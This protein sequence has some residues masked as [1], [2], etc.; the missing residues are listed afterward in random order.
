MNTNLLIQ[1]PTTAKKD[2]LQS[3]LTAHI[4][5]GRFDSARVAAAYATVSGVR[6]LLAAFEAH[7]LNESCWLLGLDDAITQPG[8]IE[9]LLSLANAE[10]R[11][12]SYE[13]ANL[14]FHPKFFAFTHTNKNKTILSLIGSANLTASALCGN[15]EAAVALESQ[16]GDDRASVDMAW[17][18]L[19][20][21]GHVP[22]NTELEA[23]KELHNKA[24]AVQKQY[25]RLSAYREG[26]ENR[27][28]QE[29]RLQR[30]RRLTI[31]LS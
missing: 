16:S 7:G 10:V 22:T 15:A 8:A 11:V 19:W 17:M 5:K 27:T 1:D 21:Q 30:C 4:R 20:V 6:T 13:D 9:L 26:R 25:R 31:S 12:A 23:Y 2:T 24:K 18:R 29:E 28:W 14:R 3:Y